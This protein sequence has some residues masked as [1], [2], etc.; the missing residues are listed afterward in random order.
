[1]F[2]TNRTALFGP[3]PPIRLLHKPVSRV[4]TRV[5]GPNRDPFMPRP[6]K[7]PFNFFSIDAREKAKELNPS[8]SMND[9]TKKVRRAGLLGRLVCCG[10]RGAAWGG[11][12]YCVV[13][14]ASSLSSSHGYMLLT[15]TWR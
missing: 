1:M 11:D 4:L 7:T 2:V 5:Q 13:H 3:M 15:A 12:T 8:I 9:L 6:N 14:N 10:A